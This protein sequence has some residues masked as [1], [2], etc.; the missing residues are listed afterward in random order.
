MNPWRFWCAL[1]C[2][3]ALT[4]CSTLPVRFPLQSRSEKTKSN[5]R[6]PVVVELASPILILGVKP[7][8]EANGPLAVTLVTPPPVALNVPLDKDNPLPI[9]TVANLSVEDKPASLVAT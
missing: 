1:C 4:S 5:E 6:A 2:L 8:V 9:V 3:L 7:P